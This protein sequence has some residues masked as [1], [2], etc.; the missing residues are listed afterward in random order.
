MWL[1]YF[2]HLFFMFRPVRAGWHYGRMRP[3]P[4]PGTPDLLGLD[5]TPDAVDGIE[6]Y[7]NNE[8]HRNQ[9]SQFH[10]N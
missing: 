3:Q 10:S 6:R 2:T 7:Q 9:Y 1:G 8:L 5:D 4:L